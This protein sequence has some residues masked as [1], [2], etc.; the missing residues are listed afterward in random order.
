MTLESL[1]TFLCSLVNGRV[2][3]GYNHYDENEQ[4]KPYI[5]YFEVNK[6]ATIFA[7]NK[8]NYYVSNIQITLVTD[9]KDIQLEKSLETSF[10]KEGLNF[11]LLSEYRSDEGEIFRAYE[12]KMEDFLN[13]K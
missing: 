1:Y 9:K 7:D 8:P 12:I 5:T 13:G 10:L 2:Y 3:Y 6:K 4:I 11:Q